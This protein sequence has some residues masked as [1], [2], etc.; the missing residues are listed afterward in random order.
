M[1]RRINRASAADFRQT[2]AAAA[3]LSLQLRSHELRSQADFPGAFA[4]IADQRPDAL[5]VL[6]DNL[7]GHQSSVPLIL[8]F[9]AGV[10]GVVNVR[11]STPCG[12]I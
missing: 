2:Q 8:D 4:A 12:H 10:P 9:A 1:H 6:P 3:A 7:T 5:V 11:A